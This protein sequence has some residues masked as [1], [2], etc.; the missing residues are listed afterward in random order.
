MRGS[1]IGAA[2]FATAK[3]AM[4]RAAWICGASA[5]LVLSTGAPT[6][7]AEITVSWTEVQQQVRPQ[8]RTNSV[9]KSIR[10]TLQGG[11]AISEHFE[12]R[13][14]RGRTFNT[15]AEGRLREGM[16]RGQSTVAWRVGDSKTLVRTASFPRS[17]LSVRVQTLSAT[18]CAATV[19]YRLKPGFSEYRM[20]G[21]VTGEPVYLSSISPQQ[22]ACSVRP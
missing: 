19:S 20:R 18:S 13:N 8:M 16:E 22:V 1:R 5:A 11:S 12:A 2:R 14:M 9:S 3:P 17:T 7:A 10:L 21:I 4:L 15:A 6:A